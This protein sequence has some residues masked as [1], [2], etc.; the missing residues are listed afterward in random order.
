ML[1]KELMTTEVVT[2]GPDTPAAEIARTLMEHAISAVPV[3]DRDGAPIGMVSEGDLIGRS[4]AER[5]A[6]RDWWLGLLAEGEEPTV[7]SLGAMRTTARTARELMAAPVITVTETTDTTDIARVLRTYRI[8]RVPVV[9]DGRIVGIV[10]RADLLRAFEAPPPAA[11]APSA[12]R[13]EGFLTE[14]VESIHEHFVHGEHPEA[15]KAQPAAGPAHDSEKVSA[16]D[17]RS[18]AAEHWNARA[19]HEEAEHEAQRARRSARVKELVEHHVGDASWRQLLHRAREAAESGEKEFLLF[20]FPAQLCSDGGRA[21]NV[22]DPA[23]P[24]TLCGEAA[25]IYLRWEHDLK[26]Q[27]FHLT[28]RVLD[29]PGGIPGDIGLFLVWGA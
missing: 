1:A 5:D 13:R 24:A 10:S 19:R 8:K 6:R 9:R 12:P 29:F 7:E 15:G 26:P 17:F 18:L 20:R 16:D 4:E 3:V 21:V 28:A 11:A 14:V 22:P 23:W 2:V 27:G 25:E